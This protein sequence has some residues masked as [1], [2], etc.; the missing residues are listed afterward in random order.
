MLKKDDFNDKSVKI[1]N[2]FKKIEDFIIKVLL[3][4]IKA[5]KVLHKNINY[6]H[7]S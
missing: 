2:V 7:Y 4:I 6:R 3:M 1:I 5:L